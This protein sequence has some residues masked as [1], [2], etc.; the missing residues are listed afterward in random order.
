MNSAVLGQNNIASIAGV[1]TV[2]NYA[3]VTGEYLSATVEYLA[4]GVGI[5]AHSCTDEPP[6]ASAGMAIF[7]TGDNLAWE[8]VPD[9]RGKTA[10]HTGTQQVLTIDYIGELKPEH[11][12]LAPKTQFDKWNGKRW[13]TDAAKQQEYEVQQAENKRQSF[14]HATEQRIVMLE[15]KKRLEMATERD[16]ALL[17]K[18]E[19]YSVKLS[20]VNCSAAPDID[21]PKAPE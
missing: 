4:V 15:R 5:P 12:R 20:D 7:R 19:F 10:H 18:W 3:E 21:W 11:T 14:L 1:I 6:A 13:V 2:Y 17:R 9:H 16:I 8:H